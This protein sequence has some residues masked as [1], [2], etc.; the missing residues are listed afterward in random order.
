MLAQWLNTRSGPYPARRKRSEGVQLS[1]RSPSVVWNHRSDSYS[2]AW[3]SFSDG[4]ALSGKMYAKLCYLNRMQAGEIQVSSWEIEAFFRGRN[5]TQQVIFIPPVPADDGKDTCP[6]SFKNYV[7]FSL[8]IIFLANLN[9]CLQVALQI[10][11]Q[12]RTCRL[13]GIRGYTHRCRKDSGIT[14]WSAEQQ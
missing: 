13:D 6:R 9:L 11:I 7:Q 3:L 4:F 2:K 5:G 14:I 10:F 12:G 8:S 1:Q